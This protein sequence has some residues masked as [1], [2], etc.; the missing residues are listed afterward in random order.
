MYFKSFCGY[1]SFGK[2]HKM[3]EKNTEKIGKY[4]KFFVIYRMEISKI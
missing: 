2:I 4:Y 3:T 1:L